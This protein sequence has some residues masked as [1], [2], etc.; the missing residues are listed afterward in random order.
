MST[1]ERL[2][3]LT[4]QL[5]GDDPELRRVAVRD[6]P[7]APMAQVLS[8]LVSALDDDD[9]RVR[10]QAIDRLVEWPDVD[11]VVG[12]MIRIL[13]DRD[14]V[15]ARNAAV[16]ALAQIGYTSVMPM[17]A[18]L[19]SGDERLRKFLIDGL[20]L[21][22]DDRAV[23]AL[24]LM[25]RNDDTNL[26]VAA[27]EAL[28]RIGGDDAERALQTTLDPAQL[29]VCSAALEALARLHAGAPMTY[30][31]P[32]LENA[33]LRP[34]ALL[35]LGWGELEGV[36]H[37]LTALGADKNREHV[38]AVLGLANMLR[39]AS[40]DDNVT[41]RDT[42]RTS[43]GED[44]GK[45][46]L[47][48]LASGPVDARSAAA[49]ILGASSVAGATRALAEGM[50]DVNASQACIEA[51]IARG[52]EAVP[53][54]VEIAADADAELRLE[55]FEALS[56]IGK[57]DP[58]LEQMLASAVVE[59][60][61]E[62]VASAAARALAEL[63]SSEVLSSLQQALSFGGPEL[64]SAAATALGRLGKD[65]SEVRLWL[66][67]GM[68]NDEPAVRAACALALGELG[69]SA[70][71]TV[72][73]MQLADPD[74]YARLAAIRGLAS[75]GE[76]GEELLRDRLG[77]EDDAEMVEAIRAALD[78]GVGEGAN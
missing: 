9:W 38:S 78:D 21:I 31:K 3:E 34:P 72:L 58:G 54:L 11:G 6:L 32:C 60:S 74:T 7:Q 70:A 47:A 67:Q 41:I 15:G 35:V 13:A 62:E 37:L 56:R 69:D 61:D 17:V 36:P 44:T 25:L 42:L 45:R 16:D 33:M 26:C 57:R 59:D 24:L 68:A 52:D 23:P 49:M 55:L 39:R 63:G 19:D 76:N 43:I 28:G 29:H 10:K 64:A 51:L 20:G 53:V 77:E 1:P 65:H 8:L 27:A 2:A 46:L 71:C 14:D 40:A 75:L 73:H 18:A 50:I 4:A 5:Q 22:G 48:T 12:A 30:L 66:S